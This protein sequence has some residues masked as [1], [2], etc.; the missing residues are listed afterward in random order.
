M[1]D[2]DQISFSSRYPS[3]IPFALPIIFFLRPRHAHIRTNN[4]HVS[5]CAWTHFISQWSSGQC[6]R[7]IKIQWY[8]G[9]REKVAIGGELNPFILIWG[10]FL[11]TVPTSSF[12]KKY[13][14]YCCTLFD[15][16]RVTCVASLNRLFKLSTSIINR[17]SCWNRLPV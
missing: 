17:L 5:M 6:R 9:V 14:E 13:G 3:K 16:F 10:L 15:V 2:D 8:A 1:G 11:H 12:V 7:A 4:K